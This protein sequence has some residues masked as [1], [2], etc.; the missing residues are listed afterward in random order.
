MTMPVNGQKAVNGTVHGLFLLVLAMGLTTATACC[1]PK[2]LADI[3]DGLN[4][5]GHHIEAVPFYRQ[6]GHAC[7]PA[8]LAGVL[9][10]W[11]R[12]VSLEDLTAK[13]V[14]PKLGGTLPMDMERAAKDAGFR[15]T[16]AHGDR[17]LLRSSV[18]GNTPVI[19]LLDLGWGPVRQPHYVTITGY[20]DGNRLFIMHDG[21]SQDRTMEYETFEKSWARAGGWMLIVQP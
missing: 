17:E 8:A 18:R 11:G 4:A 14:L 21:I 3:R 13:I 1:G 5:R 9:A 7:G 2:G 6:T 12:P 15:A 19:C 16:T 20:D 10:F